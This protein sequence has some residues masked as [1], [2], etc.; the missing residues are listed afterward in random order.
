MTSHVISTG[1]TD[2]C[3]RIFSN[4]VQYASPGTSHSV[5]DPL[6]V[7]DQ[8][9]ARVW[10]MRAQMHAVLSRI[11]RPRE[12]VYIDR[13]VG[14]SIDNARSVN[15]IYRLGSR[16]NVGGVGSFSLQDVPTDDN[17]PLFFIKR[18]RDLYES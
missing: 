13:D 6:E 3:L 5:R 16:R 4:R 17:Q 14:K 11:L 10:D 2:T 12:G 15:E 9:T 18:K 1:H 8:W 7:G